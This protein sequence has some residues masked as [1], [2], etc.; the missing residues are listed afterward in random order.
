MER[1]RALVTGP[2]AVWTGR[3]VLLGAVLFWW[4]GVLIPHLVSLAFPAW[5]APEAIPR[6]LNPDI[7]FEGRLANRV[8]AAGLFV[9]ATLALVNAVVAY[10]KTAGWVVAGGWSVLAFTAFVLAWEETTDFH[11]TLVPAI[12]SRLLD[13]P[14]VPRAGP[15]I[16]VL[17]L[18]PLIVM[19]ALVMAG[20]CV[21]GLRRAAVRRPFAIGLTAWLFAILCEGVTWVL[22]QGR[23]SALMLVLEET[24]EFGGTLLITM[25]AVAALAPSEA[26]ADAYRGR[27]LSVPI[28]GSTV[29]VFVL[30]GLYVGLVFRAPLIDGRATA[31]HAQYWVSLANQQSVAQEFPMP[32]APLARLSLRIV[33]R[34]PQQRPGAAVWRVMEAGDGSAGPILRE[35]RVQVPAGDLPVWIDVDLPL[36]AAGE[37]Q[38]LLVQVV[39]EIEQQAALRIGMVKGD[40]Y[41]D[42]RLWVNGELTW[43]DQD[44]EFVVHSASEPTISK[45]RALWRMMSSDWHWP[46]QVAKAAVG[47]TLV[48][49]IPVLLVSAAWRGPRPG[50]IS[51]GLRRG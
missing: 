10:R 24:L 22:F 27:R 38:R 29:A 32:A 13:A 30:G 34:D 25:S 41:A 14:L 5:L 18:S 50:G 3:L 28:V 1:T 35:G 21:R 6:D 16:W 33:N 7:D 48:T 36:L 31:G 8:S 15:Y 51:S 2:L 39:A 37:G 42:G 43:P 45:L 20:F 23:A 12:G 49:L 46:A 9:L 4:G 19:F 11:S 26:F 44:L 47:L 17:V 40:R